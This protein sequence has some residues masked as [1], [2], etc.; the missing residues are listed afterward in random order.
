MI[1]KHGCCVR[2]LGD[3]SLLPQDV[4]EA[5]EGAVA[6]SRHKTR[7]T[8]N[9]CMSY[10]H[11]RETSQAATIIQRALAEGVLITDDVDSDLLQSAL[12]TGISADISS[13]R[14]AA[15]ACSAAACS[16]AAAASP[17]EPC[18]HSAANFIP[19]APDL[20]I[21]TSGETRLSDFLC[22]QSSSETQLAFTPTLWPD[23]SLWELGGLMLQYQRIAPGLELRRR[24]RMDRE[25]R[26]RNRKDEEIVR[27]IILDELRQSSAQLQADADAVEAAVAAK[28]AACDEASRCSLQ[29]LRS[30][31][32]AS[33][34]SSRSSSTS[35][36]HSGRA[37]STPSP[38]HENAAVLTTSDD[39]HSDSSDGDSEPA[40]RSTSE[41]EQSSAAASPLQSPFPHSAPA[42][43]P[44]Q[45]ETQLLS[46]SGK[47]THWNTGGVTESILLH[48]ATMHLPTRLQTHPAADIIKLP[49][50]P[51]SSSEELQTELDP[52]EL[53]RRVV[54]YAAARTA[55]L[56]AFALY[57]RAHTASLL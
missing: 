30:R 50:L 5:M 39:S 12:Y 54:Q 26:E 6:A 57:A 16:T 37:H 20:L 46:G 44:P 40:R 24:Q 9:V 15:A 52:Y 51:S 49:S 25:R 42:T 27:Q 10:T 36:T 41:S 45:E 14:A 47:L 3:V 56:R 31:R 33:I 34:S 2:V 11:E 18:P 19:A 21:R 55:R 32:S 4:R 17:C 23:F 13:E 43:P 22:Y 48:R 29:P 8:L 7:V 38:S 53:Q 28:E 35:S 1:E